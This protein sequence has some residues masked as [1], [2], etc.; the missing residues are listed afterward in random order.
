MNKSVLLGQLISD[1]QA[2]LDMFRRAG[3]KLCPEK[4]AE[5]L[6]SQST[7]CM[8]QKSTHSDSL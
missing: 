8:N 4:D 1:A 5:G 6:L 2:H 7:L 3:D